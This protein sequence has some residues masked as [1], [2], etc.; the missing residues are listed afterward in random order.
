ML[1]TKHESPEIYYVVS[2]E[3]EWTVDGKT[4]KA[5]PGTAIHAKPNAVHRMINVGDG[6][7]KTVWMWWGKP[8]VLNQPSRIVEDIE[9]QP[10]G[11]K[12]SD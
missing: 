12:F 1:G 11:A 3:A 5:T 9:K 6:I 2:G 8:E 4:F 10:T 7:L